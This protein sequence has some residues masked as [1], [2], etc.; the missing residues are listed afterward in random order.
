MR[1][2]CLTVGLQLF[3]C[4]HFRAVVGDPEAVAHAEVI[5]WQHIG[6]AE[7]EDQHHLDSPAADPA[8][9][10]E[11]CHDFIVA[12]EAD[13]ARVGNDA[14]QCFLGDVAESGYFRARETGSAQSVIGDRGEFLRPRKSP[15][16]KQLTE[17]A[18]DAFRR[19]A[20][21]LLMSDGA[22]EGFKR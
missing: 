18:Q 15:A 21:Q 9:R 8:D 16:R 2:P 7:F 3:W 13:L 22:H 17:T 11:A 19:G 14:G 1:P 12:Q 10:G 20:V 6:P 4:R 5:D